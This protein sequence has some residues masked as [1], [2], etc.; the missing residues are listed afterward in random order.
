MPDADLY[1]GREQTLVKH[2]I[3]RNYLVRLAIVVGSHWDAITYVDCFS[4]PWNV[5]SEDLKD[6][7][8]SIALEELRKARDHLRKRGRNL[9]LR[10]LFLEKNRAAYRQ[11][12][13]FADQVEDASIKTKNS[14]FERS[15]EE[16]LAFV[17]Q[18]G[19]SSFAFF[20]IDPT[21]WTGYPMSSMAPLLKHKPGEVLINLMTAHILRFID[22]V[23]KQEGF[24]AWYGSE[25]YKKELRGLEGLD[26]EDALVD[27]YCEQVMKIGGFPYTCP[28]IVLHPEKDQTHF[29]LIYATRDPKGVEEFKAAEKAAM[30]SMEGARADVQ[31]RRRELGGQMDMFDS[32]VLYDPAHYDW[33]R[34]RYLAKA[35]KL[36]EESFQRNDRIAYDEA[37]ALALTLPL[38]W[39]SDLKRLIQDWKKNGK[40]RVDGLG[41]R[42]QVPQRGRGHVLVRISGFGQ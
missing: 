8:F 36:L 38:V 28:A 24:K 19:S 35:K 21:G 31:K 27:G 3:L 10:C 17:R 6:S 7:S 9:S 1:L 18:G 12:K 2:I 34:E 40:L 32:E 23:D 37:W 13:A 33:L 20:F 11:L 4:G 25:D 41:S 22:H 16:I 15:T 29:H 14:E 5:R 39:E 26:R 42:Q 30:A